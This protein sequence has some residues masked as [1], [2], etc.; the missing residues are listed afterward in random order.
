MATLE[1][2]YTIPLGKVYEHIRN[3]R[4]KRAVV[5]VREFALRHMKAGEVK[6]S[7]GVNSLILRDGI[8]KPPRRIKV[9]IVRS[10]DAAAKVWLI[11]EE[12]KAK[13]SAAK[14][15]AADESK[16]KPEAKKAD[17]KKTEAPKPATAG[18]A[19]SKADSPAAKPAQPT[20]ATKPTMAP[21]SSAKQVAPPQPAVLPIKK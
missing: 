1:R 15:K 7:E 20:P 12:E 16:K 8:Q 6:I 17:E 2:I 9:R 11:G 3:K 5:L 13:D 14:K 19:P 21:P 10:E 18:A 4:G